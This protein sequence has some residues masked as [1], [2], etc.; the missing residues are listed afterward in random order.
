MLA[1][2]LVAILNANNLD[3][4]RAYIYRLSANELI[5]LRRNMQIGLSRL[6]PPKVIDPFSEDPINKI[7]NKSLN[8]ISYLEHAFRLI[9][10]REMSNKGIPKDR[11]R[12]LIE[13]ELMKHAY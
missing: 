4:W 8:Y 1:K 5:K 7:K 11:Q 12:W 3:T 9:R 10:K 13:E 6:D 2:E